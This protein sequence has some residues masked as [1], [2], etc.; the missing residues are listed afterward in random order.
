MV[1]M[2][3]SPVVGTKS[4]SSQLIPSDWKLG[5][6]LAVIVGASLIPFENWPAQ[7]LL[8]TVVFTALAFAE[9][10]V[11]YLARR[12]ALFVPLMIVFGL[13][14]PLSQL[15]KSAAWTWTVSLWLRCTIAFLAGLWLVHVLPM[16]EL[17]KTL[18]R[19]RCPKLLVAML[20]FMYRYIFILW[21]ELAR[22]RQAREARE[23]GHGTLLMKWTTNAQ[24]I[25]LLLLRSME[26]AER[27]HQA[28]L[29]RGWD[30]SPRFLGEK[31]GDQS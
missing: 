14:V 27:T 7:G 13:T 9:V 1:D 4:S 5:L 15:N 22:L 8:L 6:T 26:R 10:P 18:L 31:Q 17:L 20:S 30:G 2:P 3:A 12:L 29:A 21:D 11:S 19:W 23:F 16:P 24:M 28:M 25:G